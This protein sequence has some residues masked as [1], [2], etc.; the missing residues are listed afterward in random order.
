VD[1]EPR[2]DNR[3]SLAP[4]PA[5]ADRVQVGDSAHANLLDHL[6]IGLHLGTGQNFLADKRLER[7]L[8]QRCLPQRLRLAPVAAAPASL[9]GQTRRI[10]GPVRLQQ[11]KHLATLK[12]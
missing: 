7:R 11:P 3:V 9:R 1:P 6:V 2:I 12:P 4:H 5:G 8:R 10:L